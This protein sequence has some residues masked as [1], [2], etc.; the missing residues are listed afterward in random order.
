MGYVTRIAPSPTGDMHIGTARTAYFSWLAARASGGTFLL[1]VDD[2]DVERNRE[3]C[4][5]VILDTMDWL[6]IGYD[7]LYYQSQRTTI[8]NN[9]LSSLREGGYLTELDNGALA[10]KWQDFMPRSW[11]DE[12]AGDI[13]ITDTNIE[14]IHNKVILARGGDKLGQ[15]T[16]QFASVVDDITLGIN[17]VIRGVDHTTNTAKQVAIWSAIDHML[18]KDGRLCPL[19]RFAHV[20]LICSGGRKLSKRDAAAS[21][22]GYQ[23]A[24]YDPDA[25]KAYLGRLGWAPAQDNKENSFLSEEKLLA[26]FL[27]EGKMRNSNAAFDV[28][29]LN[30]FDRKHK[31]LKS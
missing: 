24:G 11:R 19:P 14:Q 15:V 3:E 25:I 31:A 12:I 2:T 13:A 21:M 17:Y 16:Y 7:G 18:T 30:W 1:R 26:M 29:K 6:K 5:K 27:T 20:G 8:Y 23:K 4:V 28:Q 9:F 22:L 10:L